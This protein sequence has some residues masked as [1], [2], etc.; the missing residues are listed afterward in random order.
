[1]FGLYLDSLRQAE[2]LLEKG[3][4]NEAIH[5]LNLLE[6]GVQLDEVEKLASMLL[7]C[8]I[9]IKIGDFEKSVLLAKT[10]FRKSMELS[11]PLL[12]VDSTIT[13]LE[14]INGLGF[15]YDSPKK[16][17]SEFIKMIARSEDILKSVRDL[18][19]KDKDLRINN[20][21]KFRGIIEHSQIKIIPTSDKEIK[22]KIPNIP[23][24]KVKGVGQKAVLLKE[25]GYSTAVDLSIASITDLI[26][27]KG[28]GEATAQKLIEAAKEL[29][30]SI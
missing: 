25:A 2:E 12:V 24:E 1:M 26:K 5:E 20:L 22:A 17:Q 14:A 28:V 27:I 8:K 21:G 10:A 16:E 13:F 18:K 3:K 4:T 19:K 23:I 7:N 11:H 30:E 29:I 15:L 6:K 9:M